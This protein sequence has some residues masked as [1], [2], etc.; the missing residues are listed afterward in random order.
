MK[1]KWITTLM[2]LAGVAL[3]ASAADLDL[4]G[5][6]KY[7]KVHPQFHPYPEETTAVQSID[8][9]GPVGVGIHLLQPAFQMQVKNVEPGSPAEATGKLKKD[10]IIDSINGRVLKDMDPRQIL[11][12]IIAKAEASDGV[13]KLVVRENATANPVE[14]VVN[15]PV[16]GAYGKTWPLNDA[17]SDKIVR[18]LAEFVTKN[19]TGGMGLGALYLLST[20]DEKD[21]E[22]VRG[23]MRK[24]A[25][26]NKDKKELDVYPWGAGYG[27][28]ALCEYYLR[29]GDDSIR[30]TIKLYADCMKK[31]QFNGAWGHKGVGSC[32]YSASG[33]M[34]AAGVHVLT[35]L[36]LAKECG[37]DVDEVTLQSALKYFYK[38]AGH[39]NVAYGDSLPETTC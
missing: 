21:L 3:P 26:D 37:V 4:T 9:F 27:G 22:V 30:H 14:V 16:L 28:P 2:M 35:F 39:G 1:K 5:T 25:A 12:D 17:K 19:G 33:H 31:S 23:W 38:F 7:Y 11:G 32:S 29:T 34:N 20:G 8:R 18:N 15:I 36:M 10:Q 13:V 6:S 24:T